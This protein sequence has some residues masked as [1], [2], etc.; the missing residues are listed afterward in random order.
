[1][2]DQAR[3]QTFTERRDYS[4]HPRTGERLAREATHG[5]DGVVI[6]LRERT[7][8]GLR[9]EDVVIEIARDN[10]V[11][12]RGDEGI[13]A[14]PAWQLAVKRA[15]DIVTSIFFLIALSPILVAAAIAV[16]LTSTGPLL[17]IQ[18]RVG[19]DG[20]TFRFAKFRSMRDGA[21]TELDDLRHLNEVDGPVFKMREDPRIT[22]FGRF[23]RKY[24]IDELPQ[25]FHVLT[26][27]MSLVGPRPPIPAEVLTYDEWQR[28]R[29]L[30]KPGIT[31]I[32]QVS[33]RSDLD[34]ET[35]VEMD[36]EYI[37]TWKPSLDFLILLK[38]LPAVISARGAY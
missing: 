37:R 3:Q 21:H 6:D 13:L 38:T 24:S 36:V 17:Y 30:T 12:L 29:L 33:G 32:W 8:L 19:K 10:R 2:V 20:R 11:F 14:A 27:D 28:Q 1:M 5:S 26:G 9:G 15:V 23:M 16:K 22:P 4:V 35:W 25:L 7:A 18:D 31:C 34:F